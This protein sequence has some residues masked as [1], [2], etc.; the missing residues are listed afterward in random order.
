MFGLATK[1]ELIKLEE[2]FEYLTSQ[3]V[4]EFQ[5]ENSKRSSLPE[6]YGAR[7]AELEMKV[8]K[9][10]AVIVK[11]DARGTERPSHLARKMFGGKS[12][13]F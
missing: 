11:I 3:I 2:S 7:I 4:E 5:K 10:W 13:D 6:D 12:K 9:L 8:A 1:E